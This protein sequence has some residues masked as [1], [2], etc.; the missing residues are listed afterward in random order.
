M[1]RPEVAQGRSA[2]A[3]WGVAVGLGVLAATATLLGN[4]LLVRHFP[5]APHPDDLL[6]ELLPYVRPA[7]WLTL[8]ALVV[9]VGAFLWV[10]VRR[11]ARRLPEVAAAVAWMYLLRALLMV[12]T[13]LGP[14]QG[15]GPFIFEPRQYGMFPSG[16]VAVITLLAL[17]TPAD[18]PRLRRLLWLMVGLMI[19]G[20]LLARGHY[21]I[22]IVGALLLSYFVAH[23]WRAARPFRRWH[24]GRM[25]HEEGA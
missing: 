10:L 5:D 6:F 12:L 18:H 25:D 17:L 14:A 15:V 13:P 4:V 22:D 2:L 8:L 20:L 24:H 9:G 3:P 1:P 16:H 19:T 21:S 11:D 23:S 7:R